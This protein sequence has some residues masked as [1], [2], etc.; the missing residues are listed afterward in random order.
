MAKQNSTR[1]L[2]WLGGAMKAFIAIAATAFPF[3]TQADTWTD[4]ATEIKWTYTISGTTVKITDVGPKYPEGDVVIPTTLGSKNVTAIGNSAFDG[5][6]SIT[7][8]KIP[9]TVTSIG[10]S[11]FED[12]SALMNINIPSGVTTI[13]K[14]AFKGCS[15]LT[16]VAIPDS[17]TTLGDDVF[18]GCA[19]L[20]QVELPPA[21]TVA[22]FRDKYFSGCPT[23][24]A[25]ASRE[26]VDGLEWHYQVKDGTAEICYD[27]VKDNPAIPSSKTGTI[28]IPAT[29][30]GC[31]VT[32]IGNKA[33]WGCTKLTSVANLDSVTSIGDAAFWGCDGLADS[34]GFVIVR[35]VLHY[36]SGYDYDVTIPAGVTRIGSM[37]FMGCYFIDSVNIPGSVTSIG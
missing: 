24:L 9:I 31:P 16:S 12:C 4:P 29:L 3:S 21:F 32:S 37:A 28:T 36:Y 30:G 22:G 17:V 8:V 2:H 23:S 33:F 18:Y 19:S 11:A 5:L 26:T 13:G 27:E 1:T 6:A 10:E 14:R 34:D 25:V 20:A 15:A 7:S 35:G